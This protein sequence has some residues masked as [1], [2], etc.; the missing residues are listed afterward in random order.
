MT[1]I[2]GWYNN[3]GQ[4]IQGGHMKIFAVQTLMVALALTVCLAPTAQAADTSG[5]EHP[6]ADF[7]IGAAS[8]LCSIPY[9]V[10]KVAVAIVG[11]VTG[12]FTYV[13]SGFDKRAADAVWYTSLDGDYLV[14][15]DHLR[16]KKELHF[17]GVPPENSSG[18]H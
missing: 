12:A 13:L 11:G 2:G 8:V 3:R 10:A 18:G 1:D 14:T 5:D 17:T 16:G 9:G 6:Y 15:P 4:G 7:G